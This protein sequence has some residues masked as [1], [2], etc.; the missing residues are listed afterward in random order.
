MAA[1]VA[2]ELTDGAQRRQV[3][4]PAL[5]PRLFVLYRVPGEEDED[6][7]HELQAGGQAK[8]DEAE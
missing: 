3:L 5:S 6:K 8:V 1:G 2:D 7:T 4:A